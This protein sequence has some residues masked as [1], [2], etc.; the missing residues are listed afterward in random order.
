MHRRT[1]FLLCSSSSLLIS[2]LETLVLEIVISLLWSWKPF[3]TYA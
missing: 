2:I 3:W 1:D